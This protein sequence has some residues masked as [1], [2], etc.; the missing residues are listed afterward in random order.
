MAIHH[1][2]HPGEFI[3]SVYVEPNGI[4]GREL[5]MQHGHDLTTQEYQG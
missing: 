4:S 5:A 1:P 2:P 3:T